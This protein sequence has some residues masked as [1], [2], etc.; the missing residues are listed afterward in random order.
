MYFRA[1]ARH[2]ARLTFTRC[3]ASRTPATA[4]N[5]VGPAPAFRSPI[6]QVPSRSHSA[7]QGNRS[8]QQVS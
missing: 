1:E 8:L 3:V 6:N 5:D 2:S 7:L 4:L